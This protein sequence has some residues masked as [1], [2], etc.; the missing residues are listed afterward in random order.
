MTYDMLADIRTFLTDAARTLDGDQL[1][2]VRATTMFVDAVLSAPRT[3]PVGTYDKALDV[4]EVLR[5]G[6]HASEVTF[7]L[8]DLQ[9]GFGAL[10]VDLGDTYGNLGVLYPEDASRVVQHLIN[11]LIGSI[12]LHE[13]AQ[14]ASPGE[15]A[16]LGH[17]WFAVRAAEALHEGQTPPEM[18]VRVGVMEAANRVRAQS[19][20][21]EDHTLDA[22]VSME[23]LLLNLAR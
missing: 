13:S 21:G 16:A 22:L 5:G 6:S 18:A 12:R 7:W 11:P 8:D 20:R 3:L 14:T 15:I 4:I 10:D 23:N 2:R 17:L 9:S 1:D 19:L